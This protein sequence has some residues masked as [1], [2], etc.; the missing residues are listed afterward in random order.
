[1]AA[2]LTRPQCIKLHFAVVLGFMDTLSS[3]KWG[4]VFLCDISLSNLNFNKLQLDPIQFPLTF[5]TDI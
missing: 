2:I 3:C 5:D 1:M 4:W